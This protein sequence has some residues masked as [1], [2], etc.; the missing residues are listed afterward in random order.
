MATTLTGLLLKAGHQIQAQDL[1]VTSHLASAII[2]TSVPKA[3]PPVREQVIAAIMY[4]EVLT[5]PVSHFITICTEKE[6][7]N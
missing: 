3:K 5:A 2:Y 6:S 7:G 4:A 1:L